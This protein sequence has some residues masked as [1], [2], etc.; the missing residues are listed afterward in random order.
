MQA[1]ENRETLTQS[2][3]VLGERPSLGTVE[4]FIDCVK[5]L[6]ELKVT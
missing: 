4:E 2:Q 3:E 5:S 1:S 6:V